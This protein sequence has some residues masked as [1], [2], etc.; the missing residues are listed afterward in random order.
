MSQ[1]L[2]STELT[3]EI[4][5]F[6]GKQE[7]VTTFNQEL[8]KVIKYQ[9]YLWWCSRTF[10]QNKKFVLFNKKLNLKRDNG[11]PKCIIKIVE[12]I[13]EVSFFN[14]EIRKIIRASTWYIKIFLYY[15]RYYRYLHNERLFGNKKFLNFKYGHKLHFISYMRNR[16]LT[17]VRMNKN[18][19]SC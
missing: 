9:N 10:K 13:N 3:M 6:N 18:F 4:W 5:S 15:N 16:E 19:K 1:E 17:G 12:L 14:K 11:L 7:H 2:N 8:I